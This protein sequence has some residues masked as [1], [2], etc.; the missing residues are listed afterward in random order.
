MCNVVEASSA[1]PIDR[2]WLCVVLIGRFFETHANDWVLISDQTARETR[3]VK[4]FRNC[5]PP[6]H[7]IFISAKNIYLQSE[8]E[9]ELCGAEE[10]CWAHNPKVLGS[11]PSG[12]NFFFIWHVIGYEQ[13]RALYGESF[14]QEVI[15]RNNTSQRVEMKTMQFVWS[16]R[17]R[18]YYR[19]EILYI[20][21]CRLLLSGGPPWFFRRSTVIVS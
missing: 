12:A 6:T 15:Q 9:T 1:Y 11:K 5:F 3:K 13:K 20:I 4:D 21:N 2:N 8:K 19:K 17:D 18:I 16:R 14:S 10:A 7:S